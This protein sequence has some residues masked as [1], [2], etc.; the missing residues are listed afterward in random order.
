MQQCRGEAPSSDRSL[1]ELPFTGH[2]SQAD[3]AERGEVEVCAGR[4]IPDGPCHHD[5]AF[6]SLAE[7]SR[8]DVNADPTD[9]LIE[10]LDLSRVYRGA[11]P[12]SRIGE[13]LD[14]PEGTPKR[15]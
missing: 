11:D 10:E 1:E 5:L 8:C 3:R 9:I 6:A 13:V 4:E 2:P 7:R 14:E 15:T 12:E